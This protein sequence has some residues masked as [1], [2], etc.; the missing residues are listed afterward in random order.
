MIKYFK[1]LIAIVLST[2]VLFFIISCNQQMDFEKS[3]WN[4]Q[5]DSTFPSTYRSSMLKD[6]TANHKLIG[7]R[8]FQL[9]DLLGL[10]NNKTNN[11]LTY[12]IVVEYGSD[13]DPIYTK[14]LVFKYSKDSVITSFKVIEWKR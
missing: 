12:D 4:E 6:L 14:S 1:F 13:I 10:P 3:K 8:C 7:L 9:E 5:I 2:S 11:T